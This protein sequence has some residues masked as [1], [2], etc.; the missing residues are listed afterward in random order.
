MILFFDEDMGKRVPCAL[1]CVK[2]QCRYPGGPKSPPIST[3]DLEWIPIAGQQ[4][5]LVISANQE[6]LRNPIERR[7]LKDCDLGIVFLSSGTERIVA[8]LR[9]ILNKL[10][11]L[12]RIDSETDRPFA[13]R[14]T[15]TGRVTR[16]I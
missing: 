11:W 1:R 14:I 5:W 15:I 16:V 13:F 3:K 12:E 4:K 10:N 6:I 2:I 9:L 7:A 8:V